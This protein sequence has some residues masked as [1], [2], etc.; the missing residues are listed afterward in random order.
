MIV[1]QLSIPALFSHDLRARA[2]AIV[3]STIRSSNHASIK[4]MEPLGEPIRV[5][6]K[7]LTTDN[8]ENLR[9]NDGSEVKVF[10]GD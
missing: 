10:L 3:Q 5:I 8:V 4:I 1:E 9:D 7:G 2:S 6:A